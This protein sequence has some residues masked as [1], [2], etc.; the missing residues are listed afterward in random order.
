MPQVIPLQPGDLVGSAD[1]SFTAPIGA[2][3]YRFALHWA[4]REDRWYL[5][6]AEVGASAPIVSGVKLVLGVLLGRRCAHPLFR[7]GALILI[8]LALTSPGRG[9]EAGYFDLG[10]RVALRWY[11][12]QELAAIAGYR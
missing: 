8:D 10:R 11:D 6:L 2:D 7:R 3:L 1:Y 4:R 9:V 5:T 12:V